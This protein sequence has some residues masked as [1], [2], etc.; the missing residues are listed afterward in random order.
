MKR[1]LISGSFIFF[2]IFFAFSCSDKKSTSPALKEENVTYT[3]DSATLKGFIA[4]DENKEGKRPAIL[5]IHE[6]WGLNDYI[7]SRARQLANLGYIAMAVDMY[8][9]GKNAANPDEAGK[10][11]MPFYQN[12]QLAKNRLDAAL[13]RLKEYP[14]TDKDNIASIGYCFGGAVALNAAKLGEDVKGAVSFHGN[15]AGVPADKNLLKAKILVCHGAD[16][17]FVSQQEVEQFRHQMDS[18]GADYSIKIYPNATH[19]FTNP[20]ATKLG[21]QFNLPIAYNAEADKQSW[22]DMKAFFERIFGR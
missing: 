6:W 14:Q 4:Y 7:R 8:G 17:K 15:L 9:D 19:A 10:L 16:D 22:N 12:P 18:I 5:I 13:A 1:K 20:G 11:A 2:A 3:S 21:Q